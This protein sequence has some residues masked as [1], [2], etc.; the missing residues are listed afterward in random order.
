MTESTAEAVT[1]TPEELRAAQQI[2]ER[3]YKAF[4]Q[5][6]TALYLIDGCR[7]GRLPESVA[8]HDEVCDMALARGIQMATEAS[9]DDLADLGYILQKHLYGDDSVRRIMERIAGEG[10]ES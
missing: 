8:D 7:T 4:Q 3:I 1:I 6:W 9:E 2:Y 5:M 10:G